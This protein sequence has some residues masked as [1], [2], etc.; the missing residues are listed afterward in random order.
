LAISSSTRKAGPFL[1]NDATTVFPFAFKVFTAA[2]LLVVNTSALGIESD[3]VI[4]VDYTVTLNSN[5]DNDP[6]GSVTLADA[7]PTGERLTVTSD[8]AALQPLVLTNNG[9]FYPRV[10]NDA[11]DKITIIA[12]QLV[13]RVGRS[14]KL[15]ISSTASATLPDPVP[16]SILAWNSDADGFVNVAPGDLATV[17]G[18]AD[19]RVETFAGTGAQTAFTIAFNPGVLA[20]LD[21]S[22]SG[23]TQVAGVD[24][25]W[26]GTTVTFTTAPPNGTVIQVR[27]ARPLTPIP[28]FDT[29]LDD[30][31]AALAELAEAEAAAAEVASALAD[32]ETARDGAEAARDV[33]VAAA[34]DAIADVEAA[35]A[36]AFYDDIAA[37][38]AATPSGGFFK[39]FASDR[40]VT[41]KDNAGTEVL[42]NI[43]PKKADIDELIGRISPFTNSP[44]GLELQRVQE[45]SLTAADTD[46]LY[47]IPMFTRYVS[48]I[49]NTLYLVISKVSDNTVMAAVAGNGATLDVTGL[50]GIQTLPLF[51]NVG[52]GVTGFVT[53]DLGAGEAFNAGPAEWTTTQGRLNNDR[54]IFAN[55]AR[56]GAIESVA[57]EVAAPA[58]DSLSPFVSTM[59]DTYLEALVEDI[60]IDFA[61]E[62]RT[63]VLRRNTDTV[64]GP[65]YR[66]SFN[67]Y[68]PVRGAVVAAWS[69][70]KAYDWSAEIGV[71]VYESVYL[72][73]AAQGAPRGDVEYTGIGC[74]LFLN[75][76]VTSFTQG[77]T[78]YTDPEDAGIKTDRVWGVE[79]TQR[80]ILTGQGVRNKSATFGTDGDYATLKAAVDY[81]IRDIGIPKDDIQRGW[82]PYSD[83]C[84]P[85]HQW[86]LRAMPGH[87]EVKLPVLPDGVSFAR[88]VLCWMGMTIE[89]LDDTELKSETTLGVETYFFD[90]NMGGRILAQPNTLIWT[91]GPTTHPVHQDAQNGISIPSEANAS[92]PTAGLLFFR[93]TGLIKGGR[94]KAAGPP[95][96]AGISDGQDLTL[97]DL[98]LE[99]TGS[100]STNFVC[101]TS[102]DNL[103]P[104]RVTFDSVVARGGASNFA[105][106]TSNTVVARHGI[107]V[108]NCE[109]DTV[110]ASGA[111]FVR[112]GKQP[113][114]TY[115]ATLDPS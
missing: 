97:M 60:A 31:N 106:I 22:I 56:K 35:A 94:Y 105:F 64:S 18:Y 37:G 90:Y 36:A 47:A 77:Q 81:L 26:I 101:H 68:D 72:S 41:Y 98:T 11:F 58:L 110:S 28:N 50:T 95:W 55:P 82:W 34:D 3:L 89:L 27:Y 25:T 33:A 78:T 4:D 7:L 59:A 69:D 103:F 12:Q 48:R 39:T 70:E 75:E 63:Y 23:V 62:G 2:D 43:A 79:E 16:N 40:I 46:A 8:V 54:I 96:G 24:F 71:G 80:R 86:T 19:A 104:G 42:K 65:L 113:G 45:I 49:S 74:T 88:G 99:A 52:N 30:A 29:F 108:T 114:V 115:D 66:L 44:V 51:E 91:D 20:N 53:I 100:T 9:G 21:I 107:K 67:L 83:I 6:G 14:L 73:S 92:D 61:V 102:P 87:S 17:A 57:L 32:A 15:P 85:A 76:G 93:I 10:I 13:E 38:L 111:G 109:V 5:Q 84:T 1:G 112:V